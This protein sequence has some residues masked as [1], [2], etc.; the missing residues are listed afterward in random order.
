MK[1]DLF[2]SCGHC[3]V[4][5]ICLHIECSTFTASPFRI[6]YSSTGI[7]WPPLALLVVML[8]K[9]HLTSHSRMS[10]S[11]SVITPL[12]LSGSW[13]SFLESQV[14]IQHPTPGQGRTGELAL[15]WQVTL[16]LSPLIS[17]HSTGTVALWLMC[18][19]SHPRSLRPTHTPPQSA[20]PW[21]HQGQRYPVVWLA[22]CM[23]QKWAWVP[24]DR[25]SRVPGIKRGLW[26]SLF[27]WPVVPC[28][29][30]RKGT[31]VN[32]TLS[33]WNPIFSPCQLKEEN[34]KEDMEDSFSLSIP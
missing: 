19:H 15:H 32:I 20:A 9:A 31:Q 29:N 10:G 26:V 3:W 8:S 7:P 30:V 11:R 22:L 28:P 12:W 14:Q 34:I 21:P 17:S 2:Q 1:T 24:L 6:C 33:S 23:T 16:P 25:N 13:R 5:Q 27:P 4:V 18:G